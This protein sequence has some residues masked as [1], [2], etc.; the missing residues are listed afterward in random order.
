MK[1]ITIKKEDI[2][3]LIKLKTGEYDSIDIKELKITSDIT[4]S[5]FNVSCLIDDFIEISYKWFIFNGSL[6]KFFKNL[7]IEPLN[8]SKR[9]KE[10]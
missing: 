10:V 4:T 2:K 7:E 3:N 9:K 5:T 8:S 1:N 6:N